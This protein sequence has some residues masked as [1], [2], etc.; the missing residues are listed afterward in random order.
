[1][2]GALTAKA[3]HVPFRNSQLT[4]LLQDSLGK[5]NKAL[6][7]AQVSPSEDDVGESL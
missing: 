6:M 3:A 4:F 1:M 7:F 5:D 2:I